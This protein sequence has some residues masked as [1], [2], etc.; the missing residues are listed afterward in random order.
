MKRIISI[1]AVVIALVLSTTV[2]TAA[3]P[4]STNVCM[5]VHGEK[6]EAV[7]AAYAPIDENVHAANITYL[8]HCSDCGADYNIIE[9]IVEA[10]SYPPTVYVT[11][12]HKGNMH[13]AVYT[14]TC[15]CGGATGNTTLSWHCFGPP[16][17]STPPA[18][19]SDKD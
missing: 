3:E 14:G 1:C 18:N 19:V 2:L 13:Y 10:H 7:G 6:V 17:V 12:Y 9:H 11:D 5:H 16:C 8:A 15:A 4:V